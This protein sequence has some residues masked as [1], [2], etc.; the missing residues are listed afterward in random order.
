MTLN[1]DQ[2]ARNNTTLAN[3]NRASYVTALFLSL[4]P[5]RRQE[6]FVGYIDTYVPRSIQTTPAANAE[7]FQPTRTPPA[8]RATEIYNDGAGDRYN[9]ALG[10]VR[11]AMGID[12]AP[13][14]WNDQARDIARQSLRGYY[15]TAAPITPGGAPR[16]S[17][18]L[19]GDYRA[20]LRYLGSAVGPD[21]ATDPAALQAVLRSGRLR[22]ALA[23]GVVDRPMLEG[24]G[25]SVR[26]RS[27]EWALTR[28]E[29]SQ[30]YDTLTGASRQRLM[31]EAMSASDIWGSLGG[32]EKMVLVA[33]TGVAA[34][35]FRGAAM[36]MA[37]VYFFRRFVNRDQ[38]PIDTGIRNTNR[39]WG[40]LVERNRGIFGRL[41]RDPGDLDPA[42]RAQVVTQFLDPMTSAQMGEGAE[43]LGLMTDV[44]MRTLA[45][46]FVVDRDNNF[47]INVGRNS[48]IDRELALR[49]NERGWR[50]QYREYFENPD[51]Q[52]SLAM[53]LGYVFFDAFRDRNPTDPRVRVVEEALG[54]MPAGSIP[55]DFIGNPDYAAA[56]TAYIQLVV[57]GRDLFT[58]G[59]PSMPSRP[60]PSS[61]SLTLGAHL[62]AQSGLGVVATEGSLGVEGRERR[63]ER[64]ATLHTLGAGLG[65]RAVPK[66]TDPTIIV[67]TIDVGSGA[68]RSREVPIA[69]FDVKPPEEIFVPSLKEALDAADP[70]E[71]WEVVAGADR[72]VHLRKS[73]GV[74]GTITRVENQVA[75]IPQASLAGKTAAQIITAWNTW[76]ARA[77]DV[78]EREPNPFA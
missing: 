6:L 65:L 50:T 2:T 61:P 44:Q 14:A 34:F 39:G 72:K 26:D 54:R 32:M 70:V 4:P 57:A 77:D 5:E 67:I 16:V 18:N 24:L 1:E 23:L 78:R 58:S 15:P 12:L 52:R 25:T 51:N 55:S 74:G 19:V 69:D 13:G 30:R 63:A 71:R 43:A 41:G 10:S 76:R 20:G 8:S 48:E 17:N 7:I 33:L 62:L 9:I 40:W 36:A 46:N 59:M 53:V 3:R 75:R 73:T 21:V 64:I 11:A 60:G 27:Q 47:T 31:L 22:G 49:M 29:I 66:T 45:T 42:Q 38:S 35:K 37:G 28:G 56:N 68:T